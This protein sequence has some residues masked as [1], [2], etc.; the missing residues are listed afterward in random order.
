MKS[1]LKIALS[2]VFIL[3]SFSI[4]QAQKK[5]QKKSLLQPEVRTIQVDLNQTKGTTSKVWQKCV[6]AGGCMAY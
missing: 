2:I 4:T 5:S 3:F 6:G 1:F